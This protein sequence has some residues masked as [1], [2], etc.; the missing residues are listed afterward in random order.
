MTAAVVLRRVRRLAG[1]LLPATLRGRVLLVMLL[2]AASIAAVVAV[3]AAWLVARQSLLADA[4]AFGVEMREILAVA[5]ERNRRGQ[6]PDAIGLDIPVA[7]RP[8]GQPFGFLNDRTPQHLPRPATAYGPLWPTDIRAHLADASLSPAARDTLVAA[9]TFTDY[10]AT[11]SREIARLGVPARV[12]MQLSDGSHLMIAHPDLWRA[13][14]RPA[15]VVLLFAGALL[16]VTVTFAA[17]ARRLAEPFSTLAAAISAEDRPPDAPPLTPAGP[18]EARAL[19]EAHNALQRRIADTL[20]ERNRMLAAISHDLRTPSTRLRLRAEYVREAE[21]RDAMLRDLDEMDA[22][23]AETLD[24][25]G[26]A[27]T[28]EA[29][30]VVDFESLVQSICDDYADFGQPVSFRPPRPLSFRRVNTIFGGEPE[31]CTFDDRR[32]L[33]LACRPGAL[34]RALTNLIDNALKYGRRA[35][36]ELDA[37]AETIT[38]AVHDDGPGIPEEEW[39]SVFMPFHRLDRSRARSTGGSGLGLAIVKSVADAHQGRVT[40][41]NRAEGGLT[42]RLALPRRV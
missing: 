30:R 19:A 22:L 7:W 15:S 6:A 2:G 26:D 20:A 11:L 27:V 28:R 17:L 35:R 8:A 38:V 33:R 5:E 14:W 13:R 10:L 36:V 18:A 4:Y 41:A 16:L 24:L 21:V 31:L 1:G 12:E 32:V 39:E 9:I 23:L 25:L 42:V 40:L 3:G 29:V 37:D 34:R